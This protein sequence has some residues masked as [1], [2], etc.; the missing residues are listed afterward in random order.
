MARQNSKVSSDTLRNDGALDASGTRDP[1]GPQLKKRAP[2]IESQEWIRVALRVLVIEDDPLFA[3]SLER[4]LRRE[5]YVVDIA[6]RLSEAEARLHNAAPPDLVLLDMQLPDGVGSTLIP[7][8]REAAPLAVVLCITGMTQVDYVVRAMRS[9]A[10]DYIPKSADVDELLTRIKKGSTEAIDRLIHARATTNAEEK[11]IGDSRAMAQ[12]REVARLAAQSQSTVLITGETGTGKSRIARAIHAMSPR[13]EKPFVTVDCAAL[14]S[15]LAESEL[16][17][18]VRGAFTGAINHRAG[19]VVAA[20]DGTLF[21][22]EVSDL[23]CITQGKLL[24]VLEDR[25]VRPIGGNQDVRVRAR[26]IG[27]TRRSLSDMVNDGSFREDLYFRFSVLEIRVPPLRERREDIP[28]LA[29]HFARHFSRPERR[30]QL[31]QGLLEA[32]RAQ[33]LPGNIRE[34]RNVVERLVLLQ[35]DKSGPIERDTL[36]LAI[37]QR[38][39]AP[40]SIAEVR[41]DADDDSKRIADALL[42]AGGRIGEAADRLGMSRH[43]LRRR[44][45][46][47][48]VAR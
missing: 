8:I 11:L 30:Y 41:A 18:H 34:L 27:A 40:P 19:A 13:R 4:V 5:G 36:E 9:G 12:V 7:T 22:D 37:G 47:L 16:F 6:T 14:S 43:A 10:F 39:N 20:R 15:T 38:H 44:L 17:G 1:T 21:F 26:I 32:L 29:E 45:K 2:T 33:E 23:P 25:L 24:R 42:R 28:Q 31:S 3:S 46:R 35:H 48:S